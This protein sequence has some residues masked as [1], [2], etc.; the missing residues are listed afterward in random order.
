MTKEACYITIAVE[1]ARVGGLGNY[2]VLRMTG[3]LN[4]STQHRRNIGVVSQNK[5]LLIYLVKGSPTGLHV[6]FA[7]NENVFF[8]FGI[9]IS[10]SV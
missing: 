2:F 10:I 8:L 9:Q 1:V 5:L 4:L 3:R 6:Q 7:K